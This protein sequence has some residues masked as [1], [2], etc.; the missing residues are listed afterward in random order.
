MYT[1][2]RFGKQ[3]DVRKYA[4]ALLPEALFVY[5]KN[6]P[7]EIFIRRNFCVYSGTPPLQGERSFAVGADIIRPHKMV[8]L[9]NLEVVNHLITRFRGSF[10]SRGS[11]ASAAGG[12][13]ARRRRISQAYRLYRALCAYRFFPAA[14]RH[15]PTRVT[16]IRRRGGYYPPA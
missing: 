14:P 2:E 12:Y 16:V 10:P 4:C 13:I 5:P 8:I 15:R 11:L 1:S 9:P 7:R 3:L 6:L